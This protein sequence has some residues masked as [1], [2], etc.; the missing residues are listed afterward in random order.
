MTARKDIKIGL[1]DIETAPIRAAVWG[2]WMNNVGLNMIERDWYILSY[3][4][5]WLGD[6]KIHY[7]DK[8]KSW[9]TEDDTVMLAEL[10]QLLDEA[11]IIVAQNGRRFDAKKINA[12]FILNGF[13]PPSPYKIVDTL[14]QAK[15]SFGFTSNKLEYMTDKLCSVKKIK[16]N[17]FP[18][19]ELWKECL[20]GNQKA[21]RSMKKYNIQDV[22][23]MEELY[24]IM[25]PWMKGHPNYG[26][27]INPDEPCC[28][29][30]GSLEVQKRGTY[31]TDVG[32]YQRYNCKA[33]G[34]WLRG[35]KLL[36]SPEARRLL[37]TG[38]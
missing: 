14:E 12:R 19:F 33:C 29:R 26:L 37:L 8:R 23:S 7:S 11:D 30:C 9:D 21:W 38:V 27:Y 25:L 5:K 35:R 34:G 18:G 13:P 6:P 10:W 24:L 20:L 31:K 4:F 2:L 28:N 3:C 17:E 16:H 32:V 36:N 22:T 1:L 15:S